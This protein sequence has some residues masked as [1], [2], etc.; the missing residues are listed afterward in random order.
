M[1]KENCSE[2]IF[3]LPRTKDPTNLYEIPTAPNKKGIL[4]EHLDNDYTTAPNVN[5]QVDKVVVAY[6]QKGHKAIFLGNVSI[7]LDDTK[8]VARVKY[9]Y[10]DINDI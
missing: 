5:V 7:G 10:V 1:E 6:L 3:F 9:D 8:E 2:N 4:V